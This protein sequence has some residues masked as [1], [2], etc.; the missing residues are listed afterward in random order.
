MKRRSIWRRIWWDITASKVALGVAIWGLF[1]ELLDLAFGGSS[2]GDVV[3][4]IFGGIPFLGASG[5]IIFKAWKAKVRRAHMISSLADKLE[6]NGEGDGDIAGSL[7][8][9]IPVWISRD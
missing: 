3:I 8:P 5:W 4:T 9:D 7:F 1:I 2:D 6:K